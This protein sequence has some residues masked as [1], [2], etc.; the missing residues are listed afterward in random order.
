MVVSGRPTCARNDA[1]QRGVFPSAGKLHIRGTGF[2][3]FTRQGQLRGSERTREPAKH[4]LVR[5]RRG[6][7]TVRRSSASIPIYWDNVS[8]PNVPRSQRSRGY[9]TG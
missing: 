8:V 7:E 4:I 5:R 2:S 1:P 6:H 3:P 9:S